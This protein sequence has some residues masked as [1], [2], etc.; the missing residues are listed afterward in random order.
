MVVRATCANGGC[1]LPFQVSR[2]IAKSSTKSGLTDV[3]EKK[4]M[5]FWPTVLSEPVGM[6]HHVYQ[7]ARVTT[8]FNFPVTLWP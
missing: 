4:R 5:S 6:Y 2:L 8:I 3:S 7:F 1:E